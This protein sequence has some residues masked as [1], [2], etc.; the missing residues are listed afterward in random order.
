MNLEYPV[1]KNLIK[2][3]KFTLYK[4]KQCYYLIGEDT[5]TNTFS[6]LSIDIIKNKNK[7]SSPLS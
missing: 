5:I 6:L 1:D 2:F 7:F 4:G 3:N